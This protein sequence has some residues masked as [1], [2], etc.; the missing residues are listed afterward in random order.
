[1]VRGMRCTGNVVCFVGG[2]KYIY[3][4]WGNLKEGYLLEDVGE[5]S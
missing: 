2:E 1:M 3:C 4:R 5:M